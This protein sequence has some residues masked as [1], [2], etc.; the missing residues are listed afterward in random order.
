MALFVPT[1]HKGGASGRDCDEF[2]LWW[3]KY[4]LFIIALVSP[5]V[6]SGF[7]QIKINH[8]LDL[9]T[10]IRHRFD[11][12]IVCRVWTIEGLYITTISHQW[13]WHLWAFTSLNICLHV[14]YQSSWPPNKQVLWLISVP[15]M[16]ISQMIKH[17]HPKPMY[18]LRHDAMRD[19]TDFA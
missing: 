19:P 10:Y 14:Y 16:H 5:C 3:T 18:H 11:L 17:A 12:G 9:Y 1:R 8:E 4:W 2:I 13:H 6:W 15:S 7:E